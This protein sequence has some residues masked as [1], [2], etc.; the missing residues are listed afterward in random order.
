MVTLALVLLLQAQGQAPAAPPQP[1][2]YR[3]RDRSGQVRVTTTTP[4]PSAIVLETLF[5]RNAPEAETIT[6]T[7][8]P[9]YEE[10]R[11]QMEEAMGEKTITY[12]RDI[13]RALHAARLD[14]NS[15]ESSNT[16]D[17]AISNALWGD[18]HRV[19]LLTPFVVMAI[20]LLLAWWVGAG[21]SK[22]AKA[23][24]WAGFVLAGLFLSNIALTKTLYRPQAERMG[25][26]LSILPNY[27]GG[28]AQLRPE[29][30]Q[31]ILNHDEALSRATRPLSPAWAF[32]AEVRLARQTLSRVVVDP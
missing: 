10:L 30:Q 12:W 24:V 7:P 16:V 2:L 19:L 8:P 4:P 15:A 9:S 18:G 17:R 29:N 26:L 20:C 5:S 13:D 1:P 11:I 31:A 21:L 6:L 32:P 27:L 23:L 25:Y 28:Y 22:S 14:G 3:W